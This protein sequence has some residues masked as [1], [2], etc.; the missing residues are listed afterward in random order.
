MS[1]PEYQPPIYQ[2]TPQPSKQPQVVFDSFD[3]LKSWDL[4]K[5]RQIPPRSPCPHLGACQPGP[6]AKNLNFLHKLRDS[7][8][9]CTP[10]NELIGA[11]LKTDI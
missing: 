11:G 4:E 5:L 6:R 2:I 1:S 8:K 3:C 9:G 7:L 10:R